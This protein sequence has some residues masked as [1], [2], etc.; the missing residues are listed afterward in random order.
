MKTRA[1]SNYGTFI[2]QRIK[3]AKI[4]KY[5]VVALTGMHATTLSRIISGETGVSKPN[6]L[7]IARA[8]NQLARHEVI[9]EREALSNAGFGSDA[10]ESRRFAI[11]D[12][13]DVVV[14]GD[15]F[16]RDELAEIMEN[17]RLALEISLARI[18]RKEHGNGVKS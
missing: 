8:V 9:S 11:G 3:A 10:G 14:D 4:K 15:N 1:K 7:G 12:G 18:E 17:L 16:T 6:A 5:D 13:F 2:N